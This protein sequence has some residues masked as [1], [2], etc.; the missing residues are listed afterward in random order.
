MPRPS[1]VAALC[2]VLVLSGPA[3]LAQEQWVEDSGILD[4]AI[5]LLKEGD[6][7][8]AI[9]AYKSFLSLHP[10]V[11]DAHSDLAV[12]YVRLGELG[13]AIAEYKK[14]LALGN[15]SDPT[16]IRFNLAL[17]YYKSARFD[18]AVAEFTRVLDKQPGNRNAAVLLAGCHLQSGRNK[19]VIDLLSPYQSED[20]GDHEIAFLMGTAL[21]RDGQLEEGEHLVRDLIHKGDSAQARLILGTARLM[22]R[23]IPRA[24]SQFERALELNPN[25]PSLNTLYGKA[26]RQAGRLQD[27]IESFRRE[28]VINP[29]DFDA[30][31]YL[32]MYLYKNEQKYEEALSCFERAL[33]VRPGDVLVRFHK[34]LVY[35]LTDRTDEAL[36]LLE[37]VVQEVPDF[38]EGHAALARLY[39]RLGRRDDA[40][41]HRAILE[42]LRRQRE[43]EI[44]KKAPGPLCAFV[45]QMI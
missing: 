13:K 24:L 37:G 42:E 31:L 8:G 4:K 45:V 3:S 26:L 36:E 23:D 15:G 32:G 30:N 9:R 16:L 43:A 21:I 5:D 14:A 20:P 41:R 28:L 18:E 27:S 6:I 40:K 33:H 39:V 10:D 11:A 12:A 38:I 35:V 17:A 22:S 1:Q 25:L 19:K 2:L 29:Q 44:E 34:G 7:K